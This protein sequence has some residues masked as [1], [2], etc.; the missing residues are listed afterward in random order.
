MPSSVVPSRS[1]T[2]P[3]REPEEADGVAVRVTVRPDTAAV[4]AVLVA[5]RATVTD[6]TAETDPAYDAASVGTKVAW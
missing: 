1:S 3:A 6:R 5:T 2:V 4:S